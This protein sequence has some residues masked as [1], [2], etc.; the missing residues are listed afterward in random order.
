MIIENFAFFFFLN[1]ED[2]VFTLTIG[3]PRFK[4][5]QICKNGI[6]A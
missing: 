6:L 5:G 2:F 1:T 3:L 4:Q